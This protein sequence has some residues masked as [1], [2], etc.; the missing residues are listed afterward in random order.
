MSVTLYYQCYYP[1][2]YPYSEKKINKFCWLGNYKFTVISIV[3]SIVIINRIATLY[4]S[5][6]GTEINNE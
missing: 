5:S 4:S 1:M 3:I 6:T 2:M